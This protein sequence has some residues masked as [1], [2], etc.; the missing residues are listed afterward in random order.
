M[1]QHLIDAAVELADTLARENE[2]LTRLD[3][4]RA[5]AMLSAKQRATQA[6]EQARTAPPHATHQASP[7]LAPEV[8]RR[9]AALAEENR[10]LLE[11][12]IHVQRRIIGTVAAALPRAAEPARSYRPDGALA[13]GRKIPAFALSARA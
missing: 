12:A 3:L 8:E 13:L 5:A 9:L 7:A 2:A 11:R 6:F 10:R 4:A 1:N